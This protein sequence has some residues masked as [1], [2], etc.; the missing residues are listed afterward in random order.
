MSKQG[1]TDENLNKLRLIVE[2]IVGVYVPNW[3]NIKVKS[4]WV[5]GAINLLN[6]M[7]LLKNQAQE[8]IDIVLPTFKRSAWY[9]HFESVLL[10]MLCSHIEVERGEDVNKIVKLRGARI[11]TLKFGDRSFRIRK[12]PT[13]IMEATCLSKLIDRS[14]ISE[15]P[16]TCLPSNQVV[17]EFINTPMKVPKWPSHTQFVERCVKM[18]SENACHVFDQVRRVTYIRGQLASRELTADNSSKKDFRNLF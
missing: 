10:S 7:Q 9:A 4:S 11:D 18:T 16:L 17:K 14:D 15:P 13:I 6:Q 12:T 8:V 1:I 5:E 2:N 3:F